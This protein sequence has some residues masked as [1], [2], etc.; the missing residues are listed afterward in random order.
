MILVYDCLEDYENIHALTNS[1]QV[2][3][4]ILFSFIFLAHCYDYYYYC[5]WYYNNYLKFVTHYYEHFAL[6]LY[7]YYSTDH[8]YYYYLYNLNLD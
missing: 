4:I 1:V 3:K 2:Y 8:Y 7:N 6:S 5:Y